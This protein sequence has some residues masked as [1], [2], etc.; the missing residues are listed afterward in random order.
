MRQLLNVLLMALAVLLILITGCA[1]PYQKMGCLGGFED[2]HLKDNIYYVNVQTNAF[3]GQV[4]AMQYFHRR[5]KEICLENG[6]TDY[7]I[8]NERDTSMIAGSYGSGTIST[9][10]KPGFAGYVECLGKKR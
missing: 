10:N 5:A 6:Y 4:T 9:A 7:R 8:F 3:T 1:T 2:T